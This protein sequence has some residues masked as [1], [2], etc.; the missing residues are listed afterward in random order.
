MNEITPEIAKK[1]PKYFQL[2]S[3]DSYWLCKSCR[4]NVDQKHSPVCLV[5]EIIRLRE[6]IEKWKY[7]FEEE[8]HKHEST[9]LREIKLIEELVLAWRQ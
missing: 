1:Y 9:R 8:I 3:T 4:I 6:E 7:E 5:T 2:H